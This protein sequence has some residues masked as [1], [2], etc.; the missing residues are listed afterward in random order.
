MARSSYL[1]N[2][3]LP[4]PVVQTGRVK[5][6]ATQFGSSGARDA[7]RPR[8]SPRVKLRASQFGSSGCRENRLFA[9]HKNHAKSIAKFPEIHEKYVENVVRQHIWR[10]NYAHKSSLARPVCFNP[11]PVWSYET[12]CASGWSPFFGR[13]PSSPGSSPRKVSASATCRP[14]LPS[15]GPEKWGRIALPPPRSL[16]E[17]LGDDPRADGEVAADVQSHGLANA[18]QGRTSQPGTLPNRRRTRP[19]RRYPGR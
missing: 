12:R 15:G 7:P 16:Q 17:D 5:L 2:D 4:L 14:A 1:S 3:A 19:Q 11:W 13:S 8:A 10:A 6:R 18:A 9:S